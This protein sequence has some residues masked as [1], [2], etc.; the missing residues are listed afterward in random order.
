MTALPRSR[1]AP[2]RMARVASGL[3]TLL[4]GAVL[5]A[6]PVTSLLALGWLS[7]QMAW[8]VQ[9]QFGMA[10]EAP[11]WILGARDAGRGAGRW[12]QALGGLSANISGGVRSLTA[13]LAWSLPFTA[14]WLG[15]WWAG[16]ENSFNKGYE[17]AFAGP[18]VFVAGL[19]VA[20][21]LI[22]VIPVMLAHMAA[23]GRLAAAFQI[24][25]IC[26]VIA[27]S[28]WRFAGLAALTFL[29]G[30]PFIGVHGF[31]MLAPG[32]FPAIAAM[33]LEQIADLRGWLAIG[34]AGYTFSALWVLRSLAARLYA[35]G[36]SRAAGLRPGLWDGSLA[37]E[38]AMPARARSR[39]LTGLWVG[40]AMAAGAGIV[41]QIVVAQFIN[42]AWWRWVFHPVFALPWA[43]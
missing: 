40:I 30:L 22:P 19:G 26:G 41:A 10:A 38:V 3:L 17:Q 7:R 23:E 12:E 29:A 43:G 11:G 37:A 21:V 28:G 4:V 20:A 16:W 15:A 9:Q 8:R 18:S 33:T 25:R 6:A 14:L 31:I 1:G 5:C 32:A 39:V 2:G 42:H 13:L 27:M 34:T 24:R 36:A 35:H